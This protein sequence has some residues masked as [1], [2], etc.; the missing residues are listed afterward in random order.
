MSKQKQE[1]TDAGDAPALNAPQQIAVM[2][3]LTQQAAS[4]LVGKNARSLRDDGSAPR[5]PDGY[6]DASELVAWNVK[7][8]PEPALSDDEVERSLV[9]IEEITVAGF[10]LGALVDF[11]DGLVRDYGDGGLVVFLKMLLAE[12]QSDLRAYPQGHREPTPAELRERVDQQSANALR[13]AVSTWPWFAASAAGFAA[14]RNGS[15]RSHPR[16]SRSK[17]TYVRVA[18]RDA[19]A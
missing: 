19:P 11:L 16:V 10:S 8:L 2:K 9:I 17:R 3:Q 18:N 6:Y 12:C 13:E 15:R 5:R 14:G 1:T 4:W 7:R